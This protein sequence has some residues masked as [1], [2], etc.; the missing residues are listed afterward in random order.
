MHR[1]A[2]RTWKFF[3]LLNK[4]I[5]FLTFSLPSPS[6]LL[7][8]LISWKLEQAIV[9]CVY[10]TVKEQSTKQSTADQV[11]DVKKGKQILAGQAL[12]LDRK[13]EPVS[14]EIKFAEL[15]EIPWFT[16]KWAGEKTEIVITYWI[17]WPPPP[18]KKNKKNKTK[19]NKTKQEFEIVRIRW[20]N[21]TSH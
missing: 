19:Q 13:L 4:P 21:P 16:V 9:F 3:L 17:L 7:N 8:L 2:W 18:P 1:K 20:G 12:C 5:A 14:M 6:S 10:Y 15:Q 11:S